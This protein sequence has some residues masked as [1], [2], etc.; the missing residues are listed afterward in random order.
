MRSVFGRLIV[1]GATVLAVSAA[2]APAA[3]AV[4]HSSLAGAA[5]IRTSSPQVAGAGEPIVPPCEDRAFNLIGGHWSQLVRWKFNA[6]STPSGFNV[7]AVESVLIKSFNNI[8]GAHNN[9]GRADKVSAQNS[10]EGRTERSAGISRFG[11]CTNSDGR[12]VVAFGTL[13]R[14]VLAVTCTRH[15]RNQILEA[16]I[17][18]NS[19]YPWAITAAACSNQELLEPTVTHEVGHVFGL[20]HVGERR[21]PLLTMSTRSDGPCSNAASTLGLGDM[22]GLEDLY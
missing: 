20:G 13:P 4:S 7:G 14:G 6:A 8:T 19:R 2:A 22:L 18:I 3:V 16:D 17:R 5:S 21:H 9:C 11:G 12:N 1:L 15:F 10:Y